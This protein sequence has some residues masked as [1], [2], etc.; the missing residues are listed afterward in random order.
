MSVSHLLE[1]PLQ[2]HFT[3][4]QRLSPLL[5]REITCIFLKVT[6]IGCGLRSLIEVQVV[7]FVQLDIVIMII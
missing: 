3:L 4:P 7:D 6:V 2:A 1:L 5:L